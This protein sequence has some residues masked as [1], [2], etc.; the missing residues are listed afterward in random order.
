MKTFQQ[1]IAV[2][3]FAVLAGGGLRAQSV[4]LRADIPFDFHAGDKLMPA[5]E[6]VIHGEGPV[7]WLRAE[8]SGKPTIGLMTIGSA[9]QD[10]SRKARLDF[11]RYGNQYFLESVWNPYA[12]NGRQLRRTAREKELAARADAPVVASVNLSAS[13]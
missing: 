11:N 1:V 8:D 2:G 7:L 9:G 4:D 10:L 12:Q 5:G 6:Y 13:K 3:V